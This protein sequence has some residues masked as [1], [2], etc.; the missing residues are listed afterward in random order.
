[1]QVFACR[2]IFHVSHTFIF[3]CFK[4]NFERNSQVLASKKKFISS[5]NCVASNPFMMCQNLILKCDVRCQDPRTRTWNRDSLTSHSPVIPRNPFIK[6]QNF[7]IVCL[8]QRPRCCMAETKT[9]QLCHLCHPSIS[10]MLFQNFI[11]ECPSRWPRGRR[12]E[13]S[14]QRTKPRR[15]PSHYRPAWNIWMFEKH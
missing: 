6:C 1:M 11:M 9:L 14:K 13:Y 3:L 12:S 5:I 7:L 8:S 4:F 2:M 10:I 15:R